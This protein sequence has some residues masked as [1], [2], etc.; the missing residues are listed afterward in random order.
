MLFIPTDLGMGKIRHILSKPGAKWDREGAKNCL[1]KGDGIG[2]GISHKIRKIL[3]ILDSFMINFSNT[4]YLL[5]ILNL[6]LVKIIHKY[7][8]ICIQWLVVIWRW[9]NNVY[10]SARGD[11]R[12][13]DETRARSERPSQDSIGGQVHQTEKWTSDQGKHW[14]ENHPDLS[15]SSLNGG[16][17]QHWF[18]VL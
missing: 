15:D 2:E 13:Q 14:G 17:G 12:R 1:R 7:G 18:R 10:L 6:T 3:L 16:P 4:R 8:S 11:R 5:N 9:Y